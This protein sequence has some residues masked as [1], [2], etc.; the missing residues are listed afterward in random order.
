M[1][2]ALQMTFGEVGVPGVGKEE[3]PAGPAAC[4]DL[5][6]RGSVEAGAGAWRGQ[7]ALRQGLWPVGTPTSSTDRTGSCK[8]GVASLCS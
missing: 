7:R 1:S 5:L 2:P 8:L 6:S 3:E 4:S